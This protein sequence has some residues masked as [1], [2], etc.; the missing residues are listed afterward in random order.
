MKIPQHKISD[1]ETGQIYSRF[2]WWK[3]QSACPIR[4]HQW[5]II[6]GIVLVE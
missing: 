4:M 5:K 6:H 3:N 1:E 2:L